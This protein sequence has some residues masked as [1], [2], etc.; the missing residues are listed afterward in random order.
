MYKILVNNLLHPL[1]TAATPLFNYAKLHLTLKCFINCNAENWGKNCNGSI[2]ASIWALFNFLCL[3]SPTD[4][5]VAKISSVTFCTL[6]HVTKHA[7]SAATDYD[8]AA[9]KLYIWWHLNENLPCL[10]FCQLPHQHHSLWK[11]AS[12]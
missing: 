8:E 1:P 12:R 9:T 5:K 4:I 10:G 11:G 7:A 2:F 3:W 6:L